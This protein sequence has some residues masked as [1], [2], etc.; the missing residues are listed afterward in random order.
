VVVA[1]IAMLAAL[2]FP[3]LS[4]A[5]N[6]AK[7]TT[8][9]SNLRQIGQGTL[10]YMGDNDDLFPNMVDAGDRAFPGQWASYPDFMADI[11]QI[12]LVQD[13]LQSYTKSREI[14]HCP[15]DTG[16]AVIDDLDPTVAFLGSPSDYASFGSSYFYST[17]LTVLRETQTSLAKP[18]EVNLLYD[19]AGHW[20]GAGGEALLDDSL[21]ASADRRRQYRYNNVFV[22]MHAKSLTSDQLE[23]GYAVD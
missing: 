7:G 8:C 20:H 22:D 4:R 6:A 11:P 19:A 1:I 10:L 15:S 9:L 21:E 17:K 14:F 2:I 12:P 16:T 13:L 18:A 3:V 5:K 23:V